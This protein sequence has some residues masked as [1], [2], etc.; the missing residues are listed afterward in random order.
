MIPTLKDSDLRAMT[1]YELI[2][3]LDE[4]FPVQN[5]KPGADMEK[6]WHYAGK[7]DLIDIMINH[8]RNQENG[9]RPEKQVRKVSNN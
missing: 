2:D 6:S 4:N 9:K 8:R 5:L 1:A 3:M 7:R